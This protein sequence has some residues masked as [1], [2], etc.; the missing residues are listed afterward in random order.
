MNWSKDVGS[1]RQE[2]KHGHS[3]D[4]PA[5]VA[6]WIELEMESN[7]ALPINCSL[8]ELPESATEHLQLNISQLE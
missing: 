1:R 7:G 3:S 8:I 6:C 4:L 5:S 2:G